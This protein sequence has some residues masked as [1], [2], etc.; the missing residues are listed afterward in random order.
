MVHTPTNAPKVVKIVPTICTRAQR[1]SKCR[2]HPGPLK[3][4]GSGGS[5]AHLARGVAVNVAAAVRHDLILPGHAGQAIRRQVAVGV[6]DAVTEPPVLEAAT[7]LLNARTIASA[8]TD[9]PASPK[10]LPRARGR[11]SLRKICLHTSSA[12]AFTRASISFG[13]PA[14][15][16]TTATHPLLSA[17]RTGGTRGLQ[18]GRHSNNVCE[19]PRGD[20]T[21][22][23]RRGGAGAGGHLRERTAETDI[24]RGRQK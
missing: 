13:L 3:R 5:G 4:S 7:N 18:L 20:N 17:M 21:F 22:G 19:Q 15:V 11:P 6:R 2:Q 23:Q 16:S 24:Y 1:V 9:G 12:C 10:E 14:A 8:L